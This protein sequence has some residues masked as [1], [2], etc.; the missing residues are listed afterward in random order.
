MFLFFKG[1]MEL[2][3]EFWMLAKDPNSTELKVAVEM[4][5]LNEVLHIIDN[6]LQRRIYE[7]EA[8]FRNLW[9]YETSVSYF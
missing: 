4:T 5:I 9:I 2:G 8:K 7:T 3:L 1:K 6:R